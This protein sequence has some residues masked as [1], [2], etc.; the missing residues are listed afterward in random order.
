MS[1]SKFG[2]PGVGGVVYTDP[3]QH[4]LVSSSELS[5]PPSC[6]EP[7]KMGAGAFRPAGPSQLGLCADCPF[8]SIVV[9]PSAPR[10]SPLPPPWHL[11]AS[12]SPATDTCWLVPNDYLNPRPLGFSDTPS[13]SLLRTPILRFR[14]SLLAPLTLLPFVLT[15]AHI[16]WKLGDMWQ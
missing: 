11:Q 9:E 10:P 7:Q 4:L 1:R 14:S 5:L 15:K 3:A 16:P 6:L 2:V 13:V 12:C 8:A